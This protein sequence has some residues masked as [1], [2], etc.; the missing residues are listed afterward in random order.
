[1][2]IWDLH[3]NIARARQARDARSLQNAFRVVVEYPDDEPIEEADP[4]MLLGA[5]Q[6]LSEY[7]KHDASVMLT[8]TCRALGLPQG[9]TYADGTRRVRADLPR[10]SARFADLTRG[11]AAT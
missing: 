4:G 1:M 7:L 3:Q 5:L 6:N 11:E 8:R 9:S 2:N 10:W